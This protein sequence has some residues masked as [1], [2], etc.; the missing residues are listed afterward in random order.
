M[1][2]YLAVR[3][4]RDPAADNVTIT[5]EISDD[6]ETWSDNGVILIEETDSLQHFRDSDA[7]GENPRRF[8]RLRFSLPT[9]E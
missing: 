7:L 5:A 2:E 4:V 9:E 1:A 6:L 8:L 3:V